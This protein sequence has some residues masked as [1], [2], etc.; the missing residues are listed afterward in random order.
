MTA[1]TKRCDQHF[2]P[3]SWG[4][5]VWIHNQ[6]Y[7]GKQLYIREN[8]WTSY[9]YHLNKDEVIYCASGE[10]GI[11]FVERV[12]NGPQIVRQ[13]FLRE[14]DSIHVTPGTKHQIHAIKDSILYE[15]STHHEDQDSHRI[16]QELQ[17]LIPSVG[18]H[19]G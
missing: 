4:H 2:V 5:E 13:V 12:E 17:H 7:C 9:H 15:F 11:Y 19:R 10:V 16:S 6:E 18:V 1:V 14:G 8:K 3:K